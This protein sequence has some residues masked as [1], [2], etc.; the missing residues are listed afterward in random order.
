MERLV[1]STIARPEG[2]WELAIIEAKPYWP[3]FSTM[4]LEVRGPG[5]GTSAP[6]PATLGSEPLTLFAGG[7]A[8]RRILAE[9]GSAYWWLYGAATPNVATI[10]L[11]SS[12]HADAILRCTY[13][14][15]FGFFWT[16]LR[17]ETSLDGIKAFNSRGRELFS[18]PLPAGI[19]EV[20]QR[21]QAAVREIETT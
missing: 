18:A 20:R 13:H 2:S 1:L 17:P 12:G 4:G 19:E 16:L 15:R 9:G 8:S 10:A 5:G 3:A 11:E 7:N 6:L 14:D 21:L